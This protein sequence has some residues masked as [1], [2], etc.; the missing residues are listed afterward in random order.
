MITVD[1]R[2][3]DGLPDIVENLL[4]WLGVAN[5]DKVEKG[6]GSLADNIYLLLTKTEEEDIV[7]NFQQKICNEL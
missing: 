5:S 4:N 7:I 1:E 3:I 6:G 2:D